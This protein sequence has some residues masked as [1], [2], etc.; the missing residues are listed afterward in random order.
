MGAWGSSVFEN[1]AAGDWM[2]DLLEE[3]R[4]QLIGQAL[5]AVVEGSTESDDCSAALA[6]AE[7]VAAARGWPAR[8][9][10]TELKAWIEEFDYRPTD[11]AKSLA[12]Q[13][14]RKVRDDSELA[15]LWKENAKEA[16]KWRAGLEDL[17]ERLKKAPQERPA[18]K[19]PK[20]AAPADVK[21][22]IKRLKDL[23]SYIQ[24]T[25]AGHAKYVHVES[26]V[27][28]ET[29][30]SCLPFVAKT[31]V[32]RIGWG[33]M[34]AKPESLKTGDAALA[35]LDQFKTLQE[36][37]LNNTKVSDAT[38]SRLAK[39]TKLRELGLTGTR[40]TD[41]GLEH[42]RGLTALESLTLGLTAI[43][44]TGLAHLAG[45][46]KLKKLD[47]FKT[48]VTDDG[49]EHLTGL[50]ELG[51]LDLRYSKITGA[52]L[53]H[54]A[55]LTNLWILELD[56]TLIDDQG[57]S[58]LSKMTKLARLTMR[59]KRITDEALKTIGQL[60]ALRGLVLENTKITDSALKSLAAL[61]ALEIVHL[62]GTAVTTEGARWLRKACPK[63]TVLGKDK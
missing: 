32:L 29:L 20:Q 21:Q 30:A 51:E 31:K 4:Y 46:K 36:L 8:G 6:A 24:T 3:G 27:N 7:V 16:K 13:A 55:K 19:K 23:K 53:K 1:D 14:V 17:I 45:L 2:G 25:P 11:G 34:T 50:P 56:H 18:P 22:A 38:L 44:D 59:G 62:A 10:P 47:L 57:I 52:G 54:L 28:D 60:T 39:L 9:F 40:V 12:I 26:A 61:P 49:L 48:A 15:E 43:T 37:H 42:L 63:L 41:A 33:G 35:S 5:G 58:R